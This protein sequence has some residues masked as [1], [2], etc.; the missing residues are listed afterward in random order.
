MCDKSGNI[1]SPQY[2]TRRFFSDLRAKNSAR[3]NTRFA[4]TLGIDIPHFYI[5]I[6]LVDGRKGLAS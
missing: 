5:R 4:P 1:S 2:S 6:A 3:K